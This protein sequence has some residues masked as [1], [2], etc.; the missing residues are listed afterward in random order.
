MKDLRLPCAAAFIG[1]ALFFVA[2]APSFAS[3]EP[4]YQD[5]LTNGWEAWGW[6]SIN[7]NNASPVHSGAASIRVAMGAWEGIYWHHAAFDSSAYT[8]LV[9]WIHGGTAGGQQLH[10][11]A[12]RNGSPESSVPLMAPAANAWQKYVIS[13]DSLGATGVS[14]L[15]GFWIQS[16]SGSSQSAFYLDDVALEYSSNS[17][18]TQVTIADISLDTTINR[19]YIN[20]H[21]YGVAFASAGELQALNA[22]LNRWGGNSSSRYNWQLN[23]DNRAND[24]YYQSIAYSSSSPGGRVDEFIQD[25]RSGGAQPMITVPMLDWMTKLGPGRSKLW[26][27][28]I[29]KY[30]TQTGNDYQWEPDAGNGVLAAS[31]VPITWNDP[32][33]ANLLTNSSLQKAWVQHLTN[34]WGTAQSGGVRYYIMDN[35]HSLWHS[36]HRD[37][38]PVGASMQEIRDR[39][40]DFATRVKE[41]D[42]DALIAGFEEWG[43]SGYFYSGADQ[44]WSATNSNWN[45]ANFPDRKNNGG[46]DYM[47]WLLSQMRQREETTGRRLLD[48]FTTHIYPQN[49]EHAQD[50]TSTM[51]LMRNRST[52]QLWDT[53][54]VDPSWIGQTVMLI[55]RM[56]AWVKQH[57][58]GLPIGI[59]E[60]NWGAESHINGATAQ[61][62][63][64]GIFGREGIDLAT[65]WTT[66]DSTT[67]TFKAM[68]MFRN[69]DGTNSG[70]GEISISTTS[71]V[72]PDLVSVFGAIR[73]NDN[74]LTIMVI[75]KQSQK[76]VETRITLNSWPPAG[77][78]QVWQLTSANTIAR[79]SDVEVKGANFTNTVPAQSITLFVVPGASALSAQSPFVSGTNTFGFALAGTPGVRYFIEASSDL[80]SW[81]R[82]KTNTLATSRD[83]LVFPMAGSRQYYRAQPLP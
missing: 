42:P 62:D 2:S 35:E 52:R 5:S 28:S 60:Y 12:L 34:R 27:Y 61:A 50:V 32:N 47:P 11:Q 43:W 17:P 64:Y 41:I 68:K 65:R 31:G 36:T 3:E 81:S 10:V 24:W 51:Q 63:V 82:V 56:K 48:V 75:N 39:F 8:N 66:P 69:Y 22:P 49:G 71:G 1:L 37:V 67:P 80:Q 72:N 79:L 76:G 16:T 18:V 57:Y 73:T 9:F 4:I 77:N 53:N 58:P 13:L 54:Y 59:T 23:A 33:D 7:Y 46:M 74:V 14:D 25:S 78:A 21:I 19:H 40:F 29:L 38:H 70:F 30:G 6:A 45:P 20:P 55:P 26:S 83:T 15:D 44:Q